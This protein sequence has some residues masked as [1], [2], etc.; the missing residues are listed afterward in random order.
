MLVLCDRR[1]EAIEE[2]LHRLGIDVWQDERESVV[3]AGLDGCEDVGEREALVAQA[4]RAL[5]APPPD[6]TGP[7]LLS[8]ARLVPGSSPGQALE[9]QADA[10]FICMLKFSQKSRGSF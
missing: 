4:G 2:F 9:E 1:R 10:L 7:P 5:T 3:G 6:V 8:N